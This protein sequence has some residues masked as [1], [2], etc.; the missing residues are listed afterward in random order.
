MSPVFELR[1]ASHKMSNGGPKSNAISGAVAEKVPPSLFIFRKRASLPFVHA[2]LSPANQT[3]G[4]R[5]RWVLFLKKEE[6]ILLSGSLILNPTTIKFFLIIEMF[7]LICI[8]MVCVSATGPFTAQ[9][10]CVPAF[11]LRN[12][13]RKISNG[14]SNRMPSA[15]PS[16][17][18]PPPSLFIFW[19]RASLPFVHAPLY[20]C[21]SDGRAPNQMGSS[22]E[23]E[24]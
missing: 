10:I 1:N 7:P 19:K 16:P 11:E 15:V 14:A 21:K 17:K 6:S 4:L 24:P 9:E 3:E 2:P 22:P 13:P 18:S 20:A 23:K 5:T 8:K 12:A